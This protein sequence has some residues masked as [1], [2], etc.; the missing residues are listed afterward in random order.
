MQVLIADDHVAITMIATQLAMQAFDTPNVRVAHCVEDLFSALDRAP[1]ELLVLDLT[2]PGSLKRIELVRAIRNRPDSPRILVYSAD[3]SPCLVATALE[4]G[5]SGFVPKGEPLTSLVDGMK[6]VARG[7]RYVDASLE[8]A[9][10][11][12]PWWQL[13]SAERD[14]LTA[15]GAGRT[16]KQVA[17]DSRRAYNT[18][19][20]L[21]AH[22]MQK[23]ELRGNEELAAYFRSEGLCFELDTPYP[24]AAQSQEERRFAGN[25]VELRMGS[26]AAADIETIDVIALMLLGIEDGS[27]LMEVSTRSCR[28]MLGEFGAAEI[29]ES[30][31]FR[32]PAWR[33]HSRGS[34]WVLIDQGRVR[35]T[36]NLG[37]AIRRLS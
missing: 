21:R 24:T 7:G 33:W 26:L 10:R 4:S 27:S 2:M 19:A 30:H 34:E 23:L 9:G 12:H 28:E 8:S 17:A 32:F 35:V 15:L 5:A 29:S 1:A 13:T 37:A 18:V 3:A 16:I 6:A 14:V 11:S 20:T 22:G 31:S 25:V 36:I